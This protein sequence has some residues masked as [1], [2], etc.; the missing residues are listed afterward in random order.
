[1]IEEDLE[2]EAREI[3][4]RTKS[5]DELR[6]QHRKVVLKCILEPGANTKRLLEVLS[7]T[8]RKEE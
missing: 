1:M 3:A 7:M 8:E 5:L 6:R 2:T 4:R